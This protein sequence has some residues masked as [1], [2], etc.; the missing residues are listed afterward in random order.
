VSKYYANN[1]ALSD[2]NLTQ[3]KLFFCALIVTKNTLH[4][5]PLSTQPHPE[6]THEHD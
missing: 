5:K 1:A 2:M 6:F 4:Y 3:K